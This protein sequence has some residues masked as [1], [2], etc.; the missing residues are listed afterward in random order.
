VWCCGI[1]L[2]VALVPAACGESGS[3]TTAS[4][5]SAERAPSEDEGG[6]STG[7]GGDEEYCAALERLAADGTD[8]D[9]T[10]DPEAALAEVRSLAEAA[11]PELAADF[12]TF[13][14]TIEQLAEIP[15]DD[16]GA[17]LGELFEAMLDPEFMAAQ[18]RIDDYSS[19][20]CGI[21]FD[22]LGTAGDMDDLG[23]PGDDELG[24]GGMG[25]DDPTDISLEDIDAIEEAND[26]TAW[27]EKLSSTV[28][29]M[30]ADVQLGSGP[31]AFTVDEAL[32]MCEAMLPALSA[33][34]P[35]VT[36]A[37]ANGETTIVDT[38]SGT[39]AAV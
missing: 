33:K 39:C 32:A 36:I 19:D 12:E 25:E 37:V 24:A 31:D 38:S 34:N 6:S 17:A 20:E 4:A 21:D 26:G 15:A 1:A 14:G 9:L 5:E 22:D 18:E 35:D 28:I 23:D 30:G 29:S 11:P 8:V 7:A 16:T 10:E 2:A 13:L 27:E 3:S